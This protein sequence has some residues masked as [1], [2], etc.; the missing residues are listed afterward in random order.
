MKIV[1]WAAYSGSG[2]YGVAASI[3]V[4][5]TQIGLDSHLV[6]LHT[7]TPEQWDEWA[8]ADIHVAHTHF[9]NEM[10]GRLTRRL[11]LV[12]PSHGTPE[13]IFCSA[14]ESAKNGYGH[15]DGWMLFQY[16]MQNA[17]ARVTFWPRHQAIMETMVDKGTK[18][19]LVPLGVNHRFWAAG[20]S[21][22]AFAGNPSVFSAE[23]CHPIKWPLDLFLLWPWVYKEIPG[24]SLH[25][26]YL[27]SNVHR[28]FFP[29]I[30]RNGASYGAHV[31]SF[32]FPHTEL[33]NVFKSID[34]FIGLVRYGDF[35]R[36]SLEANAA[37]AKTIS[38]VGNEYSDYWLPEGDQRIISAELVKILRGE[39]DPRQKLPVP[40][41]SDT[42]LAMKEVYEGI[43]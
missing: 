41:I 28:W 40:D 39:V 27:P 15:G 20:K 21:G 36:L 18:I 31:S 11:R 3:S 25:A 12:F 16:W 29:L 35:N 8:D 34:F 37:G 6:D 14:V 4:A 38:Y 22:G 2:M 24:A 17:D 19:H 5:E 9:P 7:S 26:N 1:H 10:R 30:N 43:L 23:N 32:T 33:R 13:H 42:A